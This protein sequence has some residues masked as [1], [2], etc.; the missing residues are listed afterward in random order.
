[1]VNGSK[2]DISKKMHELVQRTAE[3]WGVPNLTY[4][5][6]VDNEIVD[7]NSC[8]LLNHYPHNVSNKVYR[9]GSNS[10]AI[11]STILVELEN[12]N[13]LSLSDRVIDYLPDF[14][15]GTKELTNKVKVKDLV[16]HS[17]GISKYIC[18]M[19]FFLA[20]PRKDIV[21]SYR[22]MQPVK[23]FNSSFQYSNGLYVV[24]GEV[25]EKVTAISNREF[26]KKTLFQKL[27]MDETYTSLSDTYT[28]ALAVPH[29][30]YEEQTFAISQCP[31]G[32][33]LSVGGNINATAADL[34]KWLLFNLEIAG[35]DEGRTSGYNK[36]FEAQIKI[37]QP[38]KANCFNNAVITDAYA[39]GWYR[40]CFKKYRIFEHM[41]GFPGYMSNI[42]F[43]PELKAGIILLSNK[44]D[45]WYPLEMLR[46]NFY[47][48]LTNNSFTDMFQIL[49]DQSK[50]F[51]CSLRRDLD[52]YNAISLPD[53]FMLINRKYSNPIY[54]EMI[55][56]SDK[57]EAWIT[58]NSG[59]V[60]IRLAYLG[61]NKFKFIDEHF[62]FGAFF[63]LVL[64]SISNNT[65]NATMEIMMDDQH[66]HLA[67]VDTQEFT[68][69]EQ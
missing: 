47:E 50:E 17:T 69:N 2:L 39:M 66:G 35:A 32:E 38:K 42:S 13:K 51:T 49:E 60:K 15:I 36:L 18:S 68:V 25:I 57:N 48:L 16:T 20:Y 63:K 11:A 67:W 33:A 58:L 54:G 12:Q 14:K 46:L 53:E 45:I 5:L 31:F 4:A 29:I 26:F 40:A 7:V 1:M 41:G 9:I 52:A 56:T 21:N 43:S 44:S 65:H 27:G 22:H 8:I 55:F 30:G 34:A 64:L 62:N 37:S 3:T 19:M 23:P 61:N 10:K 24:A 28:P 6:I 59:E